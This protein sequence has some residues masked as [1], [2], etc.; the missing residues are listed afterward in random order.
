MRTKELLDGIGVRPGG[1]GGNQCIKK[2]H[3]SFRGGHREGVDRMTDD[4]G[5]NMLGEVEANRKA[6]RPGALRV[7]VGN[8]RNSRKVR[9]ADG[10][11]SEIPLQVRRSRQRSGLRGRRKRAR[12]Q[13]ALRMRRSKPRMNTAIDFVEHLN[14][15][16]AQGQGFFVGR[17]GHGSVLRPMTRSSTTHTP[18]RLRLWTENSVS[19]RVRHDSP[20]P[21]RRAR[22]SSGDRGCYSGSS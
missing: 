21:K 5:V 18:R 10:H 15:F 20:T 22:G 1:V 6:T 12:Q 8:R 19:V 14:G 13:D 9:E 11:R 7:V 2:L 16:A 17:Q 3:E 4:V